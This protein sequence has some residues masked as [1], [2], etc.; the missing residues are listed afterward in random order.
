MKVKCHPI[1]LIFFLVLNVCSLFAQADN[2]TKEVIVTMQNGVEYKGKIIAKN[3]KIIVLA[4]VNGKIDLIATNVKTIEEEKYQGKYSYDNPTPSKYFLGG[5]AIPLKKGKGHY[6][7]SLLIL[8][9]VNYGISDH[10]SIGGGLEFIS[11]FQGYPIWFVNSKVGFQVSEKVHLGGG[12]AVLGFLGEGYGALGYGM[13]TFGN[14]E[15]N[16][17]IG[18]GYT[19]GENID[20]NSDNNTPLFMISGI[21]RITRIVALMSE[22]LI[23]SDDSGEVFHT[24]VHGVRL[25]SR[26][27]SFD[28]GLMSSSSSSGFVAP[29]VS[30]TKSF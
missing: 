19:F 24:G 13:T 9:S 6:N 16:I 10:V 2:K 26:R 15:K 30:Y 20:D 4:T 12:V 21:Y 28:I 22:N 29:Y 7:N 3:D 14:T 17:S 23:V 5:S 27:H 25:L 18:V 1:L 11:L 8:N